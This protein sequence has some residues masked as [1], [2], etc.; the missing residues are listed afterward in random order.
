MG[1]FHQS[2]L[3]GQFVASIVMIVGYA[4]IAVPTGILSAEMVKQTK[5]KT[6]EINTQHCI[7]CGYDIHEEDAL[8]CKKC[9]HKL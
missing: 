4:V 9:G 2:H 1:I 8:Y 7:S 3:L 5:E 6:P